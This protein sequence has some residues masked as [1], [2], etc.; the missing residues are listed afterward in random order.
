MSDLNRLADM[1]N[2]AWSIGDIRLKGRSQRAMHD[3]GRQRRAI[4]NT[5][6]DRK[7]RLVLDI[8]VLMV[9]ID[10]IKTGRG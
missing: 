10:Q 7:Y 8:P 3:I 2:A 4:S 9:S 1:E 6:N 5:C